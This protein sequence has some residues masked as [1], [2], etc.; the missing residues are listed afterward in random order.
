MNLL[1]NFISLIG[2]VILCFIAWLG[3][4]NRLVIPWKVIFWGIGLQLFIG[5]LIFVLPT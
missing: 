2:I 1:L 4:E 5:L 3:S